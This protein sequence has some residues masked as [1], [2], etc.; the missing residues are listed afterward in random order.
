M[1]T[2]AEMTLFDADL[3]LAGRLGRRAVVVA[4]EKQL[5]A[6]ADEQ[7]VEAG[8]RARR[9]LDAIRVQPIRAH[10]RCRNDDRG[11]GHKETPWCAG[12][13][14]IV[15]PLQASLVSDRLPVIFERCLKLVA[16][17][18]Q[19]RVGGPERAALQM[20]E[21]LM[22]RCRHLVLRRHPFSSAPSSLPFASGCGADEG[23]GDQRAGDPA[24][25]GAQLLQEPAGHLHRREHGHRDQL[26][27]QHLHLPPRQRD[28][29]VRVHA[30]RE[31]RARDRPQ[32]LRLR[33]RALGARRRAGQ[34]LGGRRRHRH[35]RSSSAP[36]AR[37]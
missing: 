11:R 14:D 8:E 25:S 5:A 28:A 36:R 35:A 19:A 31:L 18:F 32:Q 22:K 1:P 10:G 13:A 21:T 2:S 37:C 16:R 30:A 15:G 6:P 12:H 20:R 4:L 33:V 27:G 17:A 23:H 7:A 9:C 26:E 24:R 29:A 34:H 3:M